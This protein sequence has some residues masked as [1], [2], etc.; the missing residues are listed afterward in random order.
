MV[1][2]LGGYLPHVVASDLPLASGHVEGERKSGERDVSARRRQ[3]RDDCFSEAGDRGGG[4][5]WA[6]F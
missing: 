6:D 4:V 2:G 5:K 1:N 3:W